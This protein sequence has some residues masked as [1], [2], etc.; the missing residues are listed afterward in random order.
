M[1]RHCRHGGAN[2][3]GRDEQ[4]VEGCGRLH[5]LASMRALL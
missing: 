3:A 4:E 2:A 5:A 1:P